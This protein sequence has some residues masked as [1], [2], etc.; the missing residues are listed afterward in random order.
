MATN[1]TYGDELTL[2]TASNI[3]NINITLVL[4]LVREGKLE[5]NPPEFQSFRRIVVGHFAERYG[6]HEIDLD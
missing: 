2:H 5:I 1:G 6:E 3:Y 4:S